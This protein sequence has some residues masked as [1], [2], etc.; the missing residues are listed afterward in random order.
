MMRDGT[1][2]HFL[3]LAQRTTTQRQNKDSFFVGKDEIL[4][5]CRVRVLVGI[6]G[7]RRV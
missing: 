2:N 1:P 5:D 7:T 6:V 4:Y 3:S